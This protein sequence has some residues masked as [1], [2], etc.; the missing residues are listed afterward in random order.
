MTLPNDKLLE[1]YGD[2]WRVRTLENRPAEEK[3]YRTEE[4]DPIKIAGQRLV[5][6][7]AATRVE[8]QN[9]RAD[10][11]DEVQGWIDYALNSPEPSVSGLA[12]DGTASNNR[13]DMLETMKCER[14]G[15]LPPMR[16][17]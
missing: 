15:T 11:D 10:L 5:K 1:M 4:R 12:T 6:R 16:S 8:L 14:A 7:G 2:M 13:Q 3:R 17:G 9:I